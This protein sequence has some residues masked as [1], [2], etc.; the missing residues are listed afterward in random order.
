MPAVPGIHCI[1]T[2]GAGDSFAAG[3]IAGLCEGRDIADCARIG[4]AAA[5]CSIEQ[6]GATDGVR[7]RE[8][9]A[10]RYRMIE[11]K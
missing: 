1:D 7:N 11:M 9:V 3:L 2:T 5:S 8:Q 10:E 4:C 6:I